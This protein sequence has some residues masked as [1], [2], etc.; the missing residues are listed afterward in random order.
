M[1]TKFKICIGINS[2]LIFLCRCCRSCDYRIPLWWYY[3]A[4]QLSFNASSST[5]S[6][7]KTKII[8]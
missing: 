7:F 5:K 3:C 8:S 2:S 6:F 4:N 1:I